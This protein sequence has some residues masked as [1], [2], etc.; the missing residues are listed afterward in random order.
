MG[1][2]GELA[3]LY[4]DELAAEARKVRDRAHGNRVTY[5]PKVFIPLTMLCRD[6]CGYCTFAKAPARLASPYLD[7]DE[8]LAIARAGRAG[9]LPRGALHPGRAA[10]AA[11]PDGRP[12]AGRP[13][14][15]LDGGVPG[16]RRAGPCSTRP[17]CSPTPTP[18]PC[19]EDELAALRPV[20]ASQGMMIETLAE[21]LAAHRRAPDK[22]PGAPA[23][24]LGGGRAAGHP[25]H[26]RDPGRHRRDPAGPAR[27]ALEAIA[28]VPPAPRPRPGGDRP[29]LPA[30]AGHRHGRPPAVPARGAPCG[31]S[32][33]PGCCCP[34]RSTSRRRPTSP[35]TSAPL[36]AAGI[37]DWG[38]VSPVTADHVNPERAWPALDVLRAATEAAGPHPGPP[39]HRLPR[40]RPRARALARPGHAL[41]RARRLRRRGPGPRRRR[42]ARAATGCRPTSSTSTGPGPRPG[43]AERGGRGAGRRRPRPGGRRARR[44]SPCSA[45]GAPRCGRWPR[46]PTQLRAETVGDDVTF[47]ANRNINYTNVCTFKCRFCAFSKGPLSL[48]LRGDPYLLDLDEITRR[49]AEAEARGPPRSACRAA[50]TPNFDGDYYIDVIRAVRAGLRAH[51]HPRLHRP[52]GD[53]GGAAARGAARRVPGAPEGGRAQDPARHGGRDP[54]RRGPGRLLPR[55]DQHRAVAGGPPHRPRGR[56]ALQHH[57]HVRGGRAA[58]RR[59][60]ATWWS[61]GPCSARPAASPSSCRCPSS[62]WPRR[63]TSSAGPAGAPPSARRCSCTPSARIAYRGAIDNIQVSWVK[64]GVEPG[65]ASCSGPGPT[66]W[67]AR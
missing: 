30:Q 12:V 66:T 16:R 17:G 37:D 34:P 15:R 43:P 49:V 24:H 32:P 65:P 27:R 51:P 50:S 52:R 23:G 59:G 53:R 18:A 55:Q 10:R 36:L 20:T 28:D 2:G 8:V 47:V 33:P 35:T 22:A 45:P 21:D 1:S 13:R 39:A 42:G 44:S 14:L 61:P 9:R 56:A 3:A 7:L 26:D 54:R 6:R 67:A 31:R 29:E 19:S 48:N 38:G 25:V 46:W 57:H 4:A 62:T 63:S 41:R 58:G 64:M 5:S 40:V 60:P 11:L